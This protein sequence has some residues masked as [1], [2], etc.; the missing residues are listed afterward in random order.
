[1]SKDLLLEFPGGREIYIP[2]P[3]D[4]TIGRI[5]MMEEAATLQGAETA[6]A[7]IARLAAVAG[8][9]LSTARWTA[10]PAGLSEEAAAVVPAELT[11]REARQI[12]NACMAQARGRAPEEMV[13]AGEAVAALHDYPALNNCT[14]RQ[15]AEL[16]AKNPA[17]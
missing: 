17:A 4:E 6:L 11:L 9:L 3:S 14:L 2:C 16:A 10:R 7:F 15:L 12:V 5:R 1:M 8:L 13:S